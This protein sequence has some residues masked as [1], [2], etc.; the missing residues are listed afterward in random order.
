MSR[1]R[2]S[3]PILGRRG[4]C[5]TR[6]EVCCLG[7]GS[8]LGLGLNRGIKLWCM[9]EHVDIGNPIFDI[10][11]QKLFDFVIL[12]T[13]NHS[14][15]PFHLQ[16]H[17]FLSRH[18]AEN[19]LQTTKCTFLLTWFQNSYRPQCSP[20]STYLGTSL[21]SS[22]LAPPSILF[23]DPIRIHFSKTSTK[24]NSKEDIRSFASCKWH[25]STSSRR[26]SYH[27]TPWF[28]HRI[29]FLQDSWKVVL[30]LLLGWCLGCLD[31]LLLPIHL[32]LLSRKLK[33]S[34]PC[35][36]YQRT[37]VD[38]IPLYLWRIS[39]LLARN[40]SKASWRWTSLPLQL[41]E[42]NPYGSAHNHKIASRSLL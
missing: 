29:P 37:R 16:V 8:S 27:H 26:S 33:T 11:F 36:G 28:Y 41:K 15:L 25:A 14:Q 38:S 9:N 6:F 23:L 7:S 5:N 10:S 42:E 24:Q 30:Q 2:C 35:L 31:C 13:L 21:S 20:A 12:Y 3:T 1:C 4:M 32:L 40:N 39:Y 18:Q 22:H 34:D 19:I 17:K